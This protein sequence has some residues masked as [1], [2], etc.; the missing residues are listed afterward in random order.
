VLVPK[1]YLMPRDGDLLATGGLISA[2]GN[3]VGGN[4][5]AA[6]LSLSGNVVSALN[7]TGNIA[8]GNIATPGEVS[9]V[10][11]VSGGNVNISGT[12]MLV[13]ASLAADPGGVPLGSIYYN[14]SLG[15]LRGF[16][17]FGWQS[18]QG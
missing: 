5:Q 18:L 14:T 9:A 1:V 13:V 4:L 3:V 2:V 15:Q 10:G 11:N 6:G 12:G 8:G 17:A 16:T 7:V